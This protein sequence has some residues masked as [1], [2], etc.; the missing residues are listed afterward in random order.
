M[1]DR[2]IYIPQYI[3]TVMFQKIDSERLWLKIITFLSTERKSAM[4]HGSKFIANGEASKYN[5]IRSAYYLQISLNAV[6]LGRITKHVL[7]DC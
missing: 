1:N 2:N 6:Y 7:G 3:Q 5:Q 4:M